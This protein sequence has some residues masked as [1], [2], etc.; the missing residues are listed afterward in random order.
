MSED[1]IPDDFEINPDD[2]PPGVFY[3]PNPGKPGNDKF[4]EMP[5][6]LPWI[7]P[8]PDYDRK[9][10][11]REI[12]LELPLERPPEVRDIYDDRNESG[13]DPGKPQ[14]GIDIMIIL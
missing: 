1:D 4:P 8:K 6:D 13:K 14:R 3:I 12:P 9:K 7:P 11:G 10:P 2:L 5:E